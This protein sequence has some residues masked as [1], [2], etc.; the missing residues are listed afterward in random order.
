M[1]GRVVGSQ[2]RDTSVTETVRLIGAAGPAVEVEVRVVVW[3]VQ[4]VKTL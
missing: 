2:P 3:W 4:L 1:D